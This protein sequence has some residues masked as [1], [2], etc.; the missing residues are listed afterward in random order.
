M[1]FLPS[2]DFDHAGRSLNRL[3]TVTT[4]LGTLGEH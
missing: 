1:S 3:D 2:C 4:L